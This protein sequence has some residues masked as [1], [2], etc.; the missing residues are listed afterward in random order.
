MT[1]VLTLAA[2]A[3]TACGSGS[4]GQG[5]PGDAPATPDA[6][7]V[8]D[9]VPAPTESSDP[10]L[11]NAIAGLGG[12]DTEDGVDS[13]APEV[14]DSVGTATLNWEVAHVS[15]RLFSYELTQCTL[16]HGHISVEGVGSEDATGAP[17]TLSIEVTPLKLLH[18]GENLYDAQGLATFTADGSELVNDGRIDTSPG[19]HNFPTMFTYRYEPKT[20]KFVLAWWI[21]EENVGNGAINIEC[22][23]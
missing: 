2:F 5:G 4:G 22:D 15:N 3:L 10:R 23:G 11:A 13:E 16:D 14:V 6:A 20:A 7:A 9:A 12:N 1:V 21:G 17:S 18:S 8:S 19:G